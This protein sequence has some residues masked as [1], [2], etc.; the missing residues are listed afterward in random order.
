[1]ELRAVNLKLKQEIIERK[2]AE[3]E[4]GKF[5]ITDDVFPGID[6]RNGIIGKKEVKR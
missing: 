6:S 3:K 2:K 4:P 5:K 1:M